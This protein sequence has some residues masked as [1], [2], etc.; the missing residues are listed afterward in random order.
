MN[1]R[2]GVW[3]VNM[4]NVIK[5]ITITVLLS[6]KVNAD[7]KMSSMVSGQSLLT[8]GVV[9][10]SNSQW[11]PKI[12]YRGLSTFGVYQLVSNLIS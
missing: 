6:T 10:H 7:T 3:V 11:L 9:F 1:I 12:L 5:T 8:R 2:N 4:Q